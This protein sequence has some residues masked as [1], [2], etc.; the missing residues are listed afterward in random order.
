[1]CRC[2]CSGRRETKSESEVRA[3]TATLASEEH[4]A[5]KGAKGTP[6]PRRRAGR[7]DNNTAGAGQGEKG[8]CE[9]AR[10][11]WGRGYLEGGCGFAPRCGSEDASWTARRLRAY[12]AKSPVSDMI[13][14]GVASMR[15]GSPWLQIAFDLQAS[16]AR[17]LLQGRAVG[18]GRS[19]PSV[20]IPRASLRS[21]SE[22]EQRLLSSCTPPRGVSPAPARPRP[23]HIA[24]LRASSSAP[25]QRGR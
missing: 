5:G 10:P 15:A 16:W 1:M 2:R 7:V 3:E 14:R 24:M 4:Q 8:S 17:P 9:R 20:S 19:L 21:V 23:R 18:H 6:A 25:W 22:P 12:L 13:W 11:R